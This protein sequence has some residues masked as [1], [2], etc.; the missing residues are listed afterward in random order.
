MGPIAT[1]MPTPEPNNNRPAGL[2]GS[3]GTAVFILA[4]PILGEEVLNS[5]VGVFDVYLAGRL[6]VAATSAVGLAAYVAWLVSMLFMLVGTGTTALVARHTGARDEKQANHFANQSAA[7]AVGMGIGAFVLICTIAPFLASW[8]EMTGETYTTVVRYLRLEAT[9]YLFT[10][11]TLVGAAALRG[12]GDMKT[13]LKILGIVNVINIIISSLLVFGPGPVPSLGIDG[14]VIGTVTGRAIGGAM[15][16]VVLCRGRSGIKLHLSMLKPVTSAIKR[17]MRIGVPAA[18]DGIIMWSGH[19]LF[20]KLIANLGEKSMSEV[21]FATHI[22]GIRIEAFTY[23][24]AV[25]WSIATA[26]V[27]G[28]SLGA[29]DPRRALRAGHAAVMQCGI[30][31]IGLTAF[32]YF[33]ADFIYQT[34]HSDPRVREIGPPAL[35]LAAFFQIFL[36]TSIIYIGAL[37]G[38]GDTR[39]PLLMTL[40]AMVFVRLPLGYYF[41]I[42]LDGGLVGAWIGMCG[43]MFVRGILATIRFSRGKW[44]TTRI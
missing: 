3:V 26:T 10:S 32:Y 33:G 2:H 38:A 13:P 16:L 37:R 6:G 30:L 23:L 12:V 42:V 34:M 18:A 7:L 19:F 20:L 11:L 44:V 15:M 8:Q 4:L 24:P 17:I 9:G 29:G 39:Y 21:F 36:T 35:R 22:V 25:A 40:F 27:V 1:H 31:A 5:L 28:Q 14:I 43:D 41:G